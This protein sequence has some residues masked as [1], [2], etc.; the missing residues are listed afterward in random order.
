ML[1]SEGAKE[2]LDP[3]ALEAPSGGPNIGAPFAPKD[4][5]AGVL[6]L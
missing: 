2:K 1:G 6:G 5:I 4:N 3:L